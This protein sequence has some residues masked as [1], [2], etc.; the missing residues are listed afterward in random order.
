MKLLDFLGIDYVLYENAYQHNKGVQATE[1]T[2]I[3][4]MVALVKTKAAFMLCSDSKELAT[5]VFQDHFA[6]VPLTAAEKEMYKGK[7]V[8]KDARGLLTVLITS[9]AKV[10]VD[11][12][13][14]DRV[15]FSPS[16]IY[17][18]DSSK[19]RDVFCLYKEHTISPRQMLQQVARA[20][21]CL[22]LHYLFTRKQFRR[23]QFATVEEA[24]A[25]VRE[26][27]G[28]ALWKRRCSP[29]ENDIWMDITATIRYNDDCYR[30]NPFAHFLQL[31]AERGFAF[32]MDEKVTE[33]APLEKMQRD[34]RKRQ[35]VAFDKDH[36]KVQESNAFLQIPRGE[37]DRH[38]HKELLLGDGKRRKHCAIVNWVLH[39]GRA[40]DARLAL[41]D[42]FNGRKAS[43][44]SHQLALLEQLM[45]DCGITD[46]FDTTATRGLT[47]AGAAAARKQELNSVF[48]ERQDRPVLK[49]TV[50]L[51]TAEGCTEAIRAL[52]KRCFGSGIAAPYVPTAAQIASGNTQRKF[53]VVQPLFEK[54]RTRKTADKKRATVAGT[55]NRGFFEHHMRIARHRLRRRCRVQNLVGAFGKE[56]M[57][58]DAATQGGGAASS[59]A[60]WWPQNANK[61]SINS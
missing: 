38:G 33:R 6:T 61:Y 56:H 2:E 43:D 14:F 9:D 50:D 25:H 5:T 34:F 23:E 55:V 46:R 60:V 26:M 51:A 15:I 44:P 39:G 57:N 21:N 18:L 16:I 3:D 52:F 45:T 12:D 47:A 59:G 36:P 37:M 30:T 41:Q 40:L 20:R 24:A 53:T 4:A 54:T 32:T 13:E 19:R 28:Y 58:R 8:G 35:L 42:D 7:A 10:Y 27:D 48:A 17:G 11:L 22:H 49:A 31:L 29:A 1:Y